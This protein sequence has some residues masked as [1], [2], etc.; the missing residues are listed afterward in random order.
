MEKTKEKR[1][2]T[3]DDLSLTAEGLISL[4]FTRYEA[5]DEVEFKQTGCYPVYYEK[6]FPLLNRNICASRNLQGQWEIIVSTNA[7]DI[8]YHVEDRALINLTE[9]FSCRVDMFSESFKY[10]ERFENKLKIIKK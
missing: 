8:M 3:K 4:G 2:K 7:G 10:L 5:E 6:E 1:E 9:E